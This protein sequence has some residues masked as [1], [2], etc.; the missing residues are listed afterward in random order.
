M[1]HVVRIYVMGASGGIE[2]NE[3]KAIL[4]HLFSMNLS[5]LFLLTGCALL[6]QNYSFVSSK[7]T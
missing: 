5:L 6:D 1:H 2:L 4:L 7:Y 3:S